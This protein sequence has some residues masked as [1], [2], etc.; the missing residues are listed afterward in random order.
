[1]SPS[2]ILSARGCVD[3]RRTLTEGLRDLRQELFA[4]EGQRTGIG[5]DWCTPPARSRS[6]SV[7]WL[8][9]KL[10]HL[11][12]AEVEPPWTGQ[13]A[14]CR[15]RPSSTGWHVP[16]GLLSPPSADRLATRYMPEPAQPYRRWTPAYD[17]DA[18]ADLR[19][20]LRVDQPDQAAAPDQRAHLAAE[21]HT[22]SGAFAGRT[23]PMAVSD[24][25]ARVPVVASHREMPLSCWV[26]NLPGSRHHS[27]IEVLGAGRI[28]AG[29]GGRTHGRASNSLDHWSRRNTLV[30]SERLAAVVRWPRRSGTSCATR[31][32]S[33]RTRSTCCARSTTE[34]VRIWT[35]PTASPESARISGRPARLLARHP[36]CPDRRRPELMSESLSIVPSRSGSRCPYEGPTS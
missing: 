28:R 6:S 35:V 25:G 31:S 13:Y 21:R 9:V 7:P 18:F 24:Q 12:I 34:P 20:R 26:R 2:G 32:A 15:R 10:H 23:G 17:D 1:V 14:V 27:V 30:L 19:G 8:R 16:L 11:Q 22:S 33:W 29:F 3:R 4:L 5:V 36:L